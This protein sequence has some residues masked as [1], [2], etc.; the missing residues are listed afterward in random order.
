[1]WK[2]GLIRTPDGCIYEEGGFVS[3]ASAQRAAIAE[4][5][6]YLEDCPDEDPD[7]CWYEVEEEEGYEE[8]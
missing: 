6:N 4:R 1:M 2:F 7:N 5:K 8:D 3:R